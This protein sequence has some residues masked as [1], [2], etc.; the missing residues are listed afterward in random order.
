V[1]DMFLFFKPISY[2][3]LI[4]GTSAGVGLKLNRSDKLSRN[5]LEKKRILMEDMQINAVDCYETENDETLQADADAQGLDVE[6]NVV[7]PRNKTKNSFEI[8]YIMC[9]REEV[10]SLCQESFS[11]S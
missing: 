11:F 6:G 8:E 9:E 1:E 5:S 7:D 2:L 3:R 10:T 4:F